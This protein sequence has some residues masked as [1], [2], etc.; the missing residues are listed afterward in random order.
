MGK[1][2]I[3]VDVVV[4]GRPIQAMVDSGAS[5]SGLDLALAALL[6]IEPK[7]RRVSLRH[8]HGSSS[9]R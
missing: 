4:N 8:V 6:N 7:G 2:K 9:G 1:G 3:F 5:Y